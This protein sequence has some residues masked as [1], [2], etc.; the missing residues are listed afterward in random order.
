M[1]IGD[2]LA[3]RR[4]CFSFEF[5]APESDEGVERLMERVRALRA[6]DPGFVSV[7]YGQAGA[8]RARTLELVRRIKREHDL[9]VMAHVTCV[10][11]TAA[12]LRAVFDGLAADGIE[13]VLALRGDPPRGQERFTQREGGFRYASDL[14]A[15]LKAEYPFDIG[16]AAYP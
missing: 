3:E 1:R 14:I 15:L 6:L 2:V 7:T 9:E 16:A 12:E 5:Y 10:D 11:H 4:P 13:N 8:G